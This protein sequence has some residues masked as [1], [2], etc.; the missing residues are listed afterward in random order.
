M[1]DYDEEVV[2]T[3]HKPGPNDPAKYVSIR[4]LAKEMSLELRRL[5]PPGRELSLARTNLEQAVFWANAA[6]ARSPV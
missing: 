1:N 5:C 6:I 4:A 3:Y 2:F